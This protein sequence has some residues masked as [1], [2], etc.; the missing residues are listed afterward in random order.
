MRNGT[1]STPLNRS[2]KIR[3]RCL[4]LRP[5]GCAKFGANL[6]ASTA[7]KV[8]FLKKF[9]MAD[10]CRFENRKIGISLNATFRQTDFDE[11]WLGDAC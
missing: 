1:E 7:E 11:I 3:Y 9:K 2:P 5:Y 8:E 6:T 4:C 10:G